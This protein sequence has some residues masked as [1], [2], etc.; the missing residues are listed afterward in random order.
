MTTNRRAW[1]RWDDVEERHLAEAVQKHGT[2]VSFLIL[3]IHDKVWL[4]IIFQ[5]WDKIS[6]E[7]QTDRSGKQIQDHWC[8]R[9]KECMSLLDSMGPAPR[10]DGDNTLQ[11]QAPRLYWFSIFWRAQISKADYGP[12]R[13]FGG[14]IATRRQPKSNL[15]KSDADDGC[16]LDL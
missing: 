5:A 13:W 3:N 16:V 2:R 9:Q 6:A 11:S 8:D 1:R 10:W 7:M 15:T 4:F 14:S 12:G